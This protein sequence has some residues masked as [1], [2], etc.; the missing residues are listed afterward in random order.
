MRKAQT[1]LVPGTYRLIGEMPALRKDNRRTSDWRYNP[2]KPGQLFFYKEWEYAPNDDRP[3]VKIIEQRLYPVGDY[4]HM[5]V[6]PNES[7]ETRNLE[8]S[9]IQVED[10]PSL[11]VRREHSAR[12]AL[13]VL[14]A[15][16]AS[17]RISLMDVKIYA[18]TADAGLV[19][20]HD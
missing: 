15:L 4:E 6:A 14:D 12:F 1:K 9:L 20:K 11:W 16:V 8:E 18:A 10:T 2:I 17:G 5:S 19:P 7:A 13:D 3:Y